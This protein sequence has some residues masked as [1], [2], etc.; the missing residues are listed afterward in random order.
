[1]NN[2]PAVKSSSKLGFVLL[3]VFLRFEFYLGKF[4]K[5]VCSVLLI[6]YFVVFFNIFCGLSAIE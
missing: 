4:L 2:C 3:W 1:M 5:Q 6:I